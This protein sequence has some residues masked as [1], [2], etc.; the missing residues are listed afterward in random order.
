MFVENNSLKKSKLDIKNI[1]TLDV[2]TDEK[3]IFKDEKFNSLKKLSYNKS[4]FVTSFVSNQDIITA[5]IQLSRSIPE[6]DI[7]DILDIK[8]YE[9]VGL[10]QASDYVISYEEVNTIDEM[11]EFRLF[12]TEPETL[13]SLFLPIKEQTKFLDLIIPAPLLYKTIYKREIL[14]NNG[15]HC[16]IYFN[17]YEASA[18]FYNNGE[19]LY[20]K[21]IEFSLEQ[22]YDKYCELVGEKVNEKEFFS[23]L[24]SEGLK[25]TDGI[26]QQNLMKIFGEVF[27]TLNDIIIYIKRAFKL[28]TVENIFIGSVQG[29][30]IGL[31]DYSENYLGLQSVDF[32]F[33]YHVNTDE[34]YTDQLQY[35]MLL[36]SLDYLEDETSIVNLTMFPRPPSFLNRASGQFIV[37]TVA[38][39][40][41]GLAYPM[42]Y[43]IGAYAN[44][45]KIYALKIQDDQLTAEAN[46]YKKI[47][48][49]KKQIISGLDKR[50]A[51]LSNIYNGKAKTLISIYDKKVNYRLK[52]EIFYTIAEDLAKHD[53]HLDQ[54]YSKENTLWLSLVSSDDRKITELIKDIS[55]THFNELNSIDIELIKKDLNSTYYKGLL[56][57]DLR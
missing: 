14:Q 11:R 39:I 13:N 37:A 51:T 19:Y 5:T 53:V 41:L 54:L 43:L 25:S 50:I 52:S 46:K 21:S 20:S 26:Y 27:I 2:Y 22:I 57:V 24:E 32:N 17:M 35:L 7:Q 3:Y 12:I 56:K 8:A 15:V 6:E 45:A 28:E 30:I 44:D 10:D 40:S 4:N 47:L 48:G 49:E 42:V 23:V 9:E 55:D 18:T 38:A 16:F 34:W 31:D 36:S 1:I 33:D 29:P